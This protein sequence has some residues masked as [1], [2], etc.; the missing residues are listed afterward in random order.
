MRDAISPPPSPKIDRCSHSTAPLGQAMVRKFLCRHWQMAHIS[1]DYSK[2][3][4][5]HVI[6]YLMKRP[7]AKPTALSLPGAPWPMRDFTHLRPV[8][9]RKWM[10]YFIEISASGKPDRDKRR[11]TIIRRAESEME[12]PSHR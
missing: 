12:A 11:L 6:L 3:T 1:D 10:L 4:P 2:R 5:N 7:L 9:R 8:H